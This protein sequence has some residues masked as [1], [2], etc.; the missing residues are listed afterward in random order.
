MC[1]ILYLVVDTVTL[2]NERI[3]KMKKT[4]ALILVLITL[5]SV[6]GCGILHLDNKDPSANDE[7][8][9]NNQSNSEPDKSTQIEGTG[10]DSPEDAVTS[11]V[12]FLKAGD[13]DS[14]ISTFAVESYVKN[15]SVVEFYNDYRVFSPGTDYPLGSC[16]STSSGLSVSRRQSAVTD[17]ISRI[18][19]YF[20][21]KDTEY[22][23]RYSQAGMLQLR[24]DR[25][26][27]GFVSSVLNKPSPLS[28]IRINNT[29]AADG[30]IYTQMYESYDNYTARIKELALRI[31]AQEI[32]DVFCE[33]EIE[34][35]TYWLAMETAKYNGKWYNVSTSS[36]ASMFYGSTVVTN[37]GII[38]MDK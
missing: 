30:I 11:Y 6:S 36:T 4:V 17:E 12:T 10:F 24:D 23:E 7:T 22:E 31:G 18:Y 28:S 2:T 13:V 21:I 32:K 1:Y 27:E 15:I 8:G 38:P 33:M 35:S 14:A 34:G 16:D 3:K 20:Q 29:I 19:L 5:V 37:A 9:A 25:S 26:V